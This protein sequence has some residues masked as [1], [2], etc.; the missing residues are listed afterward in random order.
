MCLS[1]AVFA[2][3]PRV[4]CV[5]YHPPLIRD[6][7]EREGGPP[8]G[9]RRIEE[10]WRIVESDPDQI[11]RNNTFENVYEFDGNGKLI[12]YA[13]R[14]GQLIPVK[15][16]AQ[17]RVVDDGVR[18]IV[19]KDAGYRFEE[20]LVLSRVDQVA[21][22]PAK[23]LGW[24][25]HILTRSDPISPESEGRE[26][27]EEYDAACRLLRSKDSDTGN[28]REITYKETA[29]GGWRSTETNILG[30]ATTVTSKEYDAKGRL[31]A[32][33]Q[34]SIG[35]KISRFEVEQRYAEDQQ[36]SVIRISATETTGFGKDQSGRIT[37]TRDAER[38]LLYW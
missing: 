34:D 13:T 17:G 25:V 33:K 37:V 29:D 20:D 3:Q 14:E 5:L 38:M 10:K 30:G 24:E 18:A 16:D 21:V 22:F 23:D 35:E 4:W 6:M 15:Y 12:A 2:A 36:G 9:V 11:R 1:T 31:I 27:I 28:L 19:Y 32:V 26:I 8:K 7:Y